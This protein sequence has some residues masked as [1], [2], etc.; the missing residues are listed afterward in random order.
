MP[1]RPAEQ[2]VA[3]IDRAIKRRG[4]QVYRGPARSVVVSLPT[5]RR[6]RN[7]AESIDGRMRLDGSKLNKKRKPAKE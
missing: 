5:A 4:A 1:K 7:L 2:L 6:W 3:S